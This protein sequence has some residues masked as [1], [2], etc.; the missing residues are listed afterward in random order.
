MANPAVQVFVGVTA[1]ILTQ[2]T[3]AQLGIT[4]VRGDTP[5][6]GAFN[7]FS[8]ETFL[9]SPRLMIK[10]ISEVAGDVIAFKEGDHT[11]TGS[12]DLV[13]LTFPQPAVTDGSG[14]KEIHPDDGWLE[15][16][17][18][19]ITVIGNTATARLAYYWR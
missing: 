6:P 9:K 15:V 5:A 8:G 3:E 4:T 16:N 10:N 18:R 19:E 1:T 13:G 12:S 17:A 7:D 11:A 2:P 14:A